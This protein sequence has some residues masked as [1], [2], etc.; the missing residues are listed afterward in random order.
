MEQLSFTIAGKAKSFQK[1][2][3]VSDKLNMLL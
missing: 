3:M 1:T 2:D